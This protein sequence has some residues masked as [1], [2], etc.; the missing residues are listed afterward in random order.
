MG[1]AG[2]LCVYR[3]QQC[4]PENQFRGKQ[5]T[6][7]SELPHREAIQKKTLWQKMLKIH[8]TKKFFL[9]KLPIGYILQLFHKPLP[10]K[11]Q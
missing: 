1:M 10:A 7:C 6:Q 3:L 9:Q 2:V 11:G 8:L 5:D 4:F